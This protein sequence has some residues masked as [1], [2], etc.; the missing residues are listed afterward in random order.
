LVFGENKEREGNIFNLSKNA[1][2][3]REQG[4]ERWYSQAFDSR[5]R[6]RNCGDV[7]GT[8]VVQMKELNGRVNVSEVQFLSNSEEGRNNKYQQ[9]F[10][11]L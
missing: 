6:F 1:S 3:W 2:L 10:V 7:S 9:L 8:L 11:S 5:K 4:K